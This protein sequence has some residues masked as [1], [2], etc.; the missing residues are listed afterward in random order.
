[1]RGGMFTFRKDG[2]RDVVLLERGK[3]TSRKKDSSCADGGARETV[4]R[5]YAQKRGD[6]TLKGR[7]KEMRGR[8]RRRIFAVKQ[9]REARAGWRLDP[10]RRT[11]VFTRGGA[12]E[13]GDVCGADTI[14]GILLN[15]GFSRGTIDK[16]RPSLNRGG[17]NPLKAGP[18]L[19]HK[20]RGLATGRSEDAQRAL[21]GSQVK[22]EVFRTRPGNRTWLQKQ[23]N[24]P[25]LFPRNSIFRG[26]VKS[27]R[28]EKNFP[29]ARDSSP[30]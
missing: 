28:S 29:C 20:T 25:L 30:T 21:L 8:E 3:K 17:G 16:H 14:G 9:I 4:N 12:G 5:A 23:E 24:A 6:P 15:R 27:N 1:M 26:C 22:G 18:G 13:K 19:V 2:A 10:V 7:G 11:A